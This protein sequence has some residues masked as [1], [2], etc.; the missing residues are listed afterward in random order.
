MMSACDDDFCRPPLI[1]P[2]SVQVEST[3]SLAQFKAD[4]WSALN[5]GATE[6]GY[7][8]A[9]QDSLIFVGRVCSSDES[10][11]I[12]KN[13]IVQSVNEA[14]EQVA[15][16]FSVNDNNIYQY[17]PF[18]QEVA[19]YATGLT[20]GNYRGLLEFGKL[21]GSEM[22]FMD[23]DVFKAH[24]IRTGIGVPEPALVDTTATTISE[25]VA[26]KSDD[27]SLIHI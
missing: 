22:T 3:T 17:L 18:G 5:S 20:I 12:Y 23:M 16:T 19:V 24:V 8:N 1:L 2:P 13:I 26:A 6:V 21:S 11:N 15:L 27:L 14:G 25:I 4:Y 9:N 7:A 10:G